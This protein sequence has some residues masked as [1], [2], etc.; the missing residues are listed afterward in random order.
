MPYPSHVCNRHHNSWQCQI[1]NP[2]SDARDWTCNLMVPRWIHFRC[3]TMGTPWLYLSSC[4]LFL[5]DY[6]LIIC[7][8]LLS[9]HSN[10]HYNGSPRWR[11]LILFPA[12]SP[13]PTTAPGTQQEFDK[14]EWK[15]GQARGWMD[16]DGWMDGW[17]DGQ[18][19]ATAIFCC[20]H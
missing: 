4:H 14:H 12:L 7:L 6:M 3:A 16:V 15:Q 13:A 1:L 20:V 11:V 9:L 18:M 19:G 5:I 10:L 2:L 17:M 8:F